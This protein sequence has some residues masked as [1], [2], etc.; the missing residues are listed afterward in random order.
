MSD[1]KLMVADYSGGDD[2]WY[3]TSAWVLGHGHVPQGS[4]GYGYSFLLAPLARGLQGVL[5]EI[6]RPP[7]LPPGAG[8]KQGPRP[9][10]VGE[11]EAGAHERERGD[12]PVKLHVDHDGARQPERHA[13][14][15]GAQTQVEAPGIGGED[16]DEHHVGASRGRGD[17][18]PSTQ[19]SAPWH[20]QSTG[21]PAV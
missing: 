4:I 9:V 2:S 3:Y 12:R 14:G 18:D 16:R 7:N 6:H 1:G 19:G 21:P 5:L 11:Q 17:P 13:H 20:S 15:G 10:Q 8:A